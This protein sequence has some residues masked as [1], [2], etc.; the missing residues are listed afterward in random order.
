MHVRSLAFALAALL[1]A[2]VA[3]SAAQPA[4]KKGS[5][6]KAAPAASS[7]AG[8]AQAL[9]VGGW[10]GYESGDLDGVQLRVDGELPMAKLTPQLGLSFVGA[11]GFSHLTESAPA[12]D[13]SANILKIVPAVRFTL[14]VNP[15]LGF[16]GDAGLGVYW[17]SVSRDEDFGPPIG[18]RSASDSEFGFLLRF[19]AG[20][21]LAL[22]PR[23]KLGL[24]LVL[25]P[26]F[27][28]YDDTTFA[29]LGGVTYQL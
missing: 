5:S 16:F 27:N 8:G 10:L 29:I 9:V 3:A 17:A 11:L 24:Q 18:V 28:D 23:T 13:V 25:D 14:P 12:V 21:T 4:P 1:A 7:S 20:G 2:P 26:M 22:N 19:A 15:Q 6:T